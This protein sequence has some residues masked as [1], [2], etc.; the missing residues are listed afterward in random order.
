VRREFEASSGKTLRRAA[1]T[2]CGLGF[3]DFYMNGRLM[4][5]QLMNPA[6]TGYDK[7]CLYVTFDITPAI[8][9]GKNAVGVVLS[10]GRFFAPR[11]QVPVPMNTYGYPKL[12]AQVY[13]EYADGTQQTIVSDALWKLT[14]EGPIRSSSE[15]DG[16]EYD[17]RRE[18]PGWAAPGFDDSIWRPAQLVASPGGK[19]EA[20]V[21][22]PIRV[23]EVLE[24]KRIVGHVA[25]VPGTLATCPTIWM[26]DFGQAFYGVVR[27]AVSG[28]AGTRVSMRTSFNVLPDG[29][30]N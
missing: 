17:A 16:E 23:T 1:A 6:L 15:F 13:L 30:L 9:A 20:Q 11:F 22:E 10:N 8:Q 2:I 19:L 26:V 28:P 21:I 4:G 12:L 18:M 5:D 24:P 3:F 27:L 25:N 7:R 14:T 29:T